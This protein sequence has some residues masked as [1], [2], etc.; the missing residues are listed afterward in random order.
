MSNR[1]SPETICR[2]PLVLMFTVPNP[3]PKTLDGTHTYALGRSETYVI[4]PGPDL[5]EYLENLSHYLETNGHVVEGILLSHGHPDHAPGAK[6]LASLLGVPIW[7]SSA[8]PDDEAREAGVTHRFSPDSE[9]PVDGDVVRVLPTP[10]HKP[11]HVAFWLEAS[12]ILFSGDSILGEGSTLIAPPEGDMFEYM[13]SLDVMQ[14]LQPRLI[15]PGHG[16]SVVDPI[17][18]IEEYRQHRKERE[19]QL[20]EAL[21]IGP[22][23]PEELVRRVYADLS[24]AVLKLARGSVQAQL[25]KLQREGRVMER[26]GHYGTD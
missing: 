15:A 5:Q 9:F 23:S 1:V 13:H 21:R 18:K 26:G 3:G 24:P 4:D 8:T 19:A 20:L 22:A 14:A 11:D 25:D 12:R 6:R 2:A 16:P 17:A 7:T 10:G